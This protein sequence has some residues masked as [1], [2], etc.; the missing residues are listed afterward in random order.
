IIARFDAITTAWKNQE[1]LDFGCGAGGLTYRIAEHSKHVTGIDIE[2]YKLDFARKQ[3][4]RL[5][6]QPVEFIC[7]D[8]EE[9]P[10]E[11][12]RFGAI[13]CIDVIEHLP[14]PDKFLQDFYRL[15]QPGGL[16]LISFGPPWFHAHGKHMWA[17]LPGW[18]THLIFPRSVV[19]RVSGFPEITTWEQ[20]GMHKLSVSKFEKLIRNSTFQTVYL[21]RRINRVVYP[22]KFIPLIRELFIS[23]VVGVFRKPK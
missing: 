12:E 14:T 5:G 16:L 7:Y 10:L 15:L 23:E 22:I 4:E 6:T 3:A 18:W 9:I 1:V 13:F 19:M 20:L 21:D 8:G 17:K 2:A 11:K